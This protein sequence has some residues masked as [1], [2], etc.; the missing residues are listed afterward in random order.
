[1]SIRRAGYNPS[2]VSGAGKILGAAAAA[3]VAVSLLLILAARARQRGLMSHCRNNLRHLGVVAARNAALLDASC[4]GRAF[5]QRVRELEYRTV[6][7][8]WRPLRP[9]PFVCP[10]WGRTPSRPEDPSSIDYRGPRR[11][12]EKLEEI[13]RDEPLGADRPG[14]HADGGHVLFL[15]LSVREMPAL[16]RPAGESEPAWKEADRFLAD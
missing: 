6:K 5:W 13:P 10:V 8:E 4:S 16:V 9:D 1:L 2:F 11:P 12:R 3:V 14:N 15:D 7:G